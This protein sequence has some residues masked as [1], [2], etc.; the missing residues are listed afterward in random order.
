MSCELSSHRL[1]TAAIGFLLIA[2]IFPVAA[3]AAPE[4]DFV[5]SEILF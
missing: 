1:T 5:I 4:T 3:S 2:L